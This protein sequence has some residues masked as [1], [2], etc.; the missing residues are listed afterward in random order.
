VLFCESVH[1]LLMLY[2]PKLQGLQQAHPAASHP[3]YSVAYT[4]DWPGGGGCS[5]DV[6]PRSPVMPPCISSQSGSL[7]AKSMMRHFQ[8]C[9]SLSLL[10]SSPGSLSSWSSS[11]GWSS[12]PEAWLSLSSWLLSPLPPSCHM[13]CRCLVLVPR[14]FVLL[15][16]EN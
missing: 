2:P 6:V 9:L 15:S 12:L 13:L 4:E 11:Q 10:E 3:P 7:T 5:C 1:A 16:T 8:S 14:W